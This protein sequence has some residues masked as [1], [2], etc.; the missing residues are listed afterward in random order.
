MG[1]TVTS[2]VQE[3]RIALASM[4]ASM[5]GFRRSVYILNPQPSKTLN[6]KPDTLLNP[7]P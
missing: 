3:L 4:L 2:Y 1:Y 7:K 6:P 5:L